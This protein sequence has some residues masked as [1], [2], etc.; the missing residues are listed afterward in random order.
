MSKVWNNRTSVSSICPSVSSWQF[1]LNANHSNWGF[2]SNCGNRNDG[3]GVGLNRRNGK[4]DDG[5]K[6]ATVAEQQW[7][8]GLWYIWHA[9]P[10][11]PRS[12]APTPTYTHPNVNN[13][14]NGPMAHLLWI[15]PSAFFV[16]QQSFPPYSSDNVQHIALLP[17]FSIM[18]LNDHPWNADMYIDF[19]ETSHLHADSSILPSCNN[20]F[21]SF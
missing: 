16:G 11:P 7:R 19:E 21:N 17:P 4:H 10:T 15:S 3:R 2:N 14:T 1:T 9:F 5:A 13:Q 12:L 6:I 8:L 20:K 18:N